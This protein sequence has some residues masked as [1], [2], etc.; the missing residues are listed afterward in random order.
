M[1]LKCFYF[2][3]FC[4]LSA[5]LVAPNCFANWQPKHSMSKVGCKTQCIA[6]VCNV[7]CQ[8]Y[9][10][11]NCSWV[12]KANY[13]FEFSHVPLESS[14]DMWARGDLE[15][16][17][18][19]FFLFSIWRPSWPWIG[20]FWNTSSPRRALHWSRSRS[21]FPFSNLPYSFKLETKYWS[22]VRLRLNKFY[23]FLNPRSGVLTILFWLSITFSI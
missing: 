19:F 1:R 2:F 15:L 8:H 20:S 21:R 7:P 18:L 23:Y 3:R 4:A 11:Q 5:S 9:P 6:L 10:I 14:P 12:F 17:G 22:L 13:F 16:A